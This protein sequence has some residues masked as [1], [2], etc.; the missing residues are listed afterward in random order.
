MGLQ[1]VKLLDPLNPTIVTGG[2]VPRGAYNAGTN[3][4]VGDS[5]DY[6]GSS[7]VMFNDVGAGTVPT[8][9]DY[10]QIL[11]EKGDTGLTG[12]TGDDGPQGDPGD[13]GE[14][15][16]AGGTTG[17]VL[18][19]NSDTDYD[20]EWSTGGGG[21]TVDT[22]VAG[23]NIDIDATDPA[24]PIVSVETLTLA[25]V[26]DVTATITELN[27]IDGVTSGIQSQINTKLANV[28]EDT[29]PQL[30]GDL[31]VNGQKITSAGNIVTKL[32]DAL[33]ANKI[34]V[35]DSANAE[36]LSI[37]SNGSVTTT[38][39]I[40]TT[41]VDANSTVTKIIQVKGGDSASGDAG[42]V[43]ITGGVGTNVQAG[44]IL[45][46]PGTESG[47]GTVGNV[48][49]TDPITGNNIIFDTSSPSAHRT[50][51]FPDA[52]LDLANVVDTANSP[53]ANE[54][55]RFTDANTIEGRTYAEVK[56]D[57]DLEIGTDVQAYDAEL[58]ALAGLT[59]A[60]NKLPR[61]TGSGTADLLD[62]KDEDNMSSD[63]ATALPSQQSVKAYSDTL[64]SGVMGYVN[65][66]ATAGTSRPSGFAIV[67]WYGTATPSN[68]TDGDVWIDT[69]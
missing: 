51:T 7:Y 52:N 5:V 38:G 64:K 49:I 16:P 59:S 46:E 19:K 37:D 36:Q 39:H 43:K 42:D 27:Y 8:D 41:Y 13:D 23:N 28:V 34:S 69:N 2:L 60:A 66:G 26:S 50:I 57:L 25:D 4:A 67:Y 12:A 32:G 62:F 44:H 55:A 10:W 40:Y 35:T 21:G 45:L 53:N 22:V 17:Q 56:A 47:S 11:A 63:S 61:F 15:V 48:K 20:V 6:Q 18:A 30:G 29:S 14:G 65:H 1:I 54:F 68:A 24:N 58:A 31:D 33:G 3:Y 9:T